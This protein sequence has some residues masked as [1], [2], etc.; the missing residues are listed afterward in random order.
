MG[1]EGP[2]SGGLMLQKMLPIPCAILP[3]KLR[4]G[5][6][7]GAAALCWA[8]TVWLESAGVVVIAWTMFG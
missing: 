5:V 1:G 8:T 3:K 4:F 2:P 7:L 6:V